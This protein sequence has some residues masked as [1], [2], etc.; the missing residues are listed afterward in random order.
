MQ[1][2]NIIYD[3]I[4]DSFISIT[5]KKLNM[6]LTFLFHYNHKVKKN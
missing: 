6:S 5:K 2:L 1:I 4:I 3:Y